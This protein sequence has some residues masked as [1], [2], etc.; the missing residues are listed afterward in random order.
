MVWC[1]FEGLFRVL[2]LLVLGWAWFWFH[3]K[4]ML[5]F[6][7]QTDEKCLR[8][9][10][11][12]VEVSKSL[13]GQRRERSERNFAEDAVA[14]PVDWG[15]SQNEGNAQQISTYYTMH[16]WSW[17]YVY[18]FIYTRRSF[19]HSFSLCPSTVAHIE[20]P[21]YIFLWKK[22]E[23]NRKPFHFVRF[24]IFRNRG[25]STFHFVGFGS[26]LYCFLVFSSSL[27]GPFWIPINKKIEK[28]LKSEKYFEKI[29][30]NKKR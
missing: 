18:I 2:L 8:W 13:E 6:F 16:M 4:L 24:V 7:V 5:S 1:Q 12:A 11:T 15:M 20:W 29:K 22:D 10:A 23:T 25:T 19:V 3:T 17:L 21:Q 26:W 9:N 28:K 27:K 30:R 14:V